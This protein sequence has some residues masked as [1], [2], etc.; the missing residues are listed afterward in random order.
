[1]RRPVRWLA[2]VLVLCAAGAYGVINLS[3]DD[4]ARWHVDPA[5]IAM[6]GTPN[7]FLAA[8]PGTTVAAPHLESE[9]HATDPRDLLVCFD[10]IARGH[11]RVAELA[12]SIDSLMITYVQ[13]SRIVGFPDYITV[14]AVPLET[15][16]G[17]A[18]A[19]LIVHSRSRYGYGD[20]GVNA[21]RVT[22]WLEEARTT[23]QGKTGSG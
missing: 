22:A 19:G 10:R 2:V 13:R 11:P 14:K 5:T 9:V 4:P 20:F 8:P 18:G 23:C 16:T 6:R 7:E 3:G 17:E 21:H 12:G 15:G 1:V